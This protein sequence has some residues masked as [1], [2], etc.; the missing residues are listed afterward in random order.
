MFLGRKPAKYLPGRMG[1]NTDAALPNLNRSK[2]QEEA[3]NAVLIESVV[4]FFDC[5]RPQQKK[6]IEFFGIFFL[7]VLRFVPV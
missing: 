6:Y 1:D 7:L 2:Q 5:R 4:Y 3:L